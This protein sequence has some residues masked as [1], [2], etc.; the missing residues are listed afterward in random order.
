VREG[1]T[2][3]Y[4]ILYRRHAT[5]AHRLARTL[6]PRR[7]E[8]DELV[9]EAFARVLAAL[10][11]GSGPRAAFRTYLL[12]TV[13]NVFY[14]EAR[15]TRRVELSDDLTRHDPGEAFVDPAVRGLELA[16]VARAFAALP[17]RWRLVLWHTEVEGHS[18]AAVARL[19]G[20]R[21]NAVSALAYR[22]RERLR[23]NYLREHAATRTGEACRWAV[24]RLGAYVRGGLGARDRAEVD[25]HLAECRPC[26]LLYV[27]LGEVNSGLGAI[28]VP[29][30]VGS[31][32]VAYHTASS[33]AG[34]GTGGADTSD[35]AGGTVPTAGGG[36][37]GAD[38]SRRGWDW[39][40]RTAE[41]QVA[42]IAAVGMALVVL[43]TTV[44]VL[45]NRPEPLSGPGR[46]APSP[47]G[48]Q[49]PPG[50]APTPDPGRPASPTPTPSDPTPPSPGAAVDQPPGGGGP[51][52]T[53]SDPPDTPGNPGAPTTP[54]PGDAG[55]LTVTLT[56]VGALVRGRPGVLAMTVAGAV[57]ATAA[58]GRRPG[59]F[60]AG[61]LAPTGPLTAR[62]TL[63]AGITLASGDAGDGWTCGAGS[64]GACRRGPLAP[65]ASSTAYLPVRVSSAARGGTGRITLDAPGARTSTASLRLTVVDRGL[66]PVY[67]RTVP[68]RLT[69]A[70]NALLSCPDLDLTCRAARAGRPALG[71]TDN[72]D[73]LMTRYAAA[74]AP[75]GVPRHG[76]VSGASVTLT[77][78]VL[79][80]GLYWAGTGR[81]PGRPT[82]YVRVPG[83]S[84]YT[85]VRAT[86][87]ETFPRR[88]TGRPGYQAYVEVT[89]LARAARSGTWWVGVDRTAFSPG[90]GSF[91]G[92]S[93]LAV[94]ADGGPPR[95]VAVLDGAVALPR[96]T[97]A[98][99]PV[100]GAPGAPAQVGFVGWETDRSITGD[101]LDLGGRPID[102]ANENN[103]A[104]SRTDGT[105][106]GWNTLGTDARVLQTRLPADQPAVVTARTGRDVWLLG[107]LAIS[108]GASG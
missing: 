72:D 104:A 9:A 81:P 95:V 90:V 60:R 37:A 1:D 15:R 88:L 75:S 67:A 62:V 55:S 48:P 92:W 78:K 61:V 14:D 36:T 17:E 87:V 71:R 56:P 59:A 96:G 99:V 63:P 33:A 29:A 80:A 28:L 13:R 8:A 11:A 85:P 2:E 25:R 23:Q 105:A 94:V 107:A 4:A 50:T 91:G 43:A 22:A 66:A 26:R 53:P 51:S 38:L 83:A 84:R 79:W 7:S 41:T 69:A 30:V 64:S 21:P 12:T 74:N 58:G 35:A 46:A 42:K 102:G 34:V 31:T 57:G 97:S 24:E 52:S 16:M 32:A 18:P 108:A 10:R 100:P 20:I 5:A 27:E 89:A 3:A 103:A 106:S 44:L 47:A 54:G 39:L 65:A 73:Y 93:L 82:A 98:R 40:R 101:R 45:A 86:R 76:M 6:E 19:L 77:G 70:G 68:A 49:A